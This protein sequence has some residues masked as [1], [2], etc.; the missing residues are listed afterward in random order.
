MRASRFAS[1]AVHSMATRQRSIPMTVRLPA[2]TLATVHVLP[3]SAEATDA[4]LVA[5]ARMG[6]RAAEAAIYARHVGFLTNL[7]LRLLGNRQDAEDTAQD[8]FV[9]VFEQLHTLREPERLRHWL[10]RIAVHKVH[11]KFRRRKLLRVLGMGS[12]TEEEIAL[13]PARA[14]LSP[15]QRI[16][17]ARLGAVLARLPDSQRAA[18]ALRYVDGYKLEEVAALCRCSLA[19]AKRRIAAADVVVRSYVRLDEVEND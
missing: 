14:G 18:W 10:S 1:L 5:R 6:E 7:C 19:S 9:D 11:R 2:Q 4:V 12:H 15:D 8:T 16:E 3:R 13:L 17:L